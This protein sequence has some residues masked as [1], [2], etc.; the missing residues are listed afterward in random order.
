MNNIETEEV[1]Q[2][3]QPMQAGVL[4]QKLNV[5]HRQA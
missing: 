5:E 3:R 4:E 1:L 2:T